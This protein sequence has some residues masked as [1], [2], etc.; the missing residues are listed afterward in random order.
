VPD[1]TCLSADCANRGGPFTYRTTEVPKRD[2]THH[3]RSYIGHFQY[4]KIL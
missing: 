2:K 3:N 1:Y 4:W